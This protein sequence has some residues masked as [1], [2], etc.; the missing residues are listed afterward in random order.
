MSWSS[1]TRITSIRLSVAALLLGIAVTL[2]YRPFGQ[3]VRGDCGI[4]DYIAQSILRGQLPYR[5]V[6]DPKAPASMYLSAMAMAIGR[7]AGAPDVVAVRCLYVLMAGL[8][9]AI[10]CLTAEAYLRS[11]VA[12]L[13][14]SLIPLIP[15]NFVLMMT[16]GTQPKLPMMIFGMLALLLVAK[17]RPF[18]AGFCSMLS[19]LCWQPGLLFAGAA[20]LVF[21]RYFT[22]WRDWRAVKVV[23]GTAVPLAVVL[24]YFYSRGALSDLWSWTITYTFSVFRPEGQK[25]LGQALTQI[26]KISHR[27]FGS[28]L[29]LPGLSL[30]GFAIYAAGRVREKLQE[31]LRSID[32]FRD[33]ILIPP[34][35]YLI[36]CIIDFQGGPDLIPFLPFI[37]LFAAWFIVEV[38]RL[39]VSI[40]FV[41]RSGPAI[42]WNFLVP[43]IAMAAMLVLILIRTTGYKPPSPS[44]REQASAIGQI[45]AYLGPDDRI[46]VHGTAEI[47][48]LLNRAN[49]NRYIALDSGADDYIAAQKAGGFKDVID[50]IESGAP[51]LVA[52]SRLRNVRHSKD[53]EQWVEAHYDTLGL[54]GCETIYIRK[55]E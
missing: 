55:Q 40:P 11:R 45:A 42:G 54:P 1:L 50:E 48:V 43:S 28:D 20:F 4:Y 6:I 10:T 49:L 18:W 25:P 46:Y 17:D 31:G 39:I 21:S 32:L 19:C 36:F 7:S 35:V 26:W 33:A 14:A 41:K 27:E 15:D 44:L 52:I 9:S 2:A 37:G 34:V 8:L 16:K 13:I 3:T 12:A 24:L 5:D 23:A 29:I 51:K 38:G 53:L 47:L 30:I 22:N